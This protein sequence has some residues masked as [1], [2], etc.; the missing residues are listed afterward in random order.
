MA[1]PGS[2]RPDDASTFGTLVELTYA[3]RGVAASTF[4]KLKAAV[5][6]YNIF[7]MIDYNVA[8]HSS[9]FHQAHYFFLRQNS[10]LK[11]L[12]VLKIELL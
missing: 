3:S 11:M 8:I 10:T 4:G 1:P 9:E 7:H 5:P 6:S 2:H 12:V